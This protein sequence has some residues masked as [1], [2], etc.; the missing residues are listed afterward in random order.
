MR[1]TIT[2]PIIAALSFGVAACQSKEADKIEDAAEN[3]ADAID[4]MADKAPTEAQEDALENKADA[5]RA[6]GEEDA[7]AKDD[8]GEIAPSEVPGNAN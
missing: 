4:T 6:Q 7:N 5:V 8:N 3:R 2:L 1:K